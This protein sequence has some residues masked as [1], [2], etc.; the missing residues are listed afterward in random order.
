M[1]SGA[2]EKFMLAY[3]AG[4]QQSVT[5]T[6]NDP[7]LSGTDKC[8]LRQHIGVLMWKVLVHAGFLGLGLSVLRVSRPKAGPLQQRGTHTAA[9]EDIR[10]EALCNRLG[11]E[12]CSVC[13]RS[14]ILE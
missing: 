2:E 6:Q 10:G 7:L 12:K 1:A 9:Q 5:S 4:P 3:T 8:P 13:P 14:S 11:L